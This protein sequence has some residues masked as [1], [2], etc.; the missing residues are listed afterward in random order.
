MSLLKTHPPM[1]VVL[2]YR[3]YSRITRVFKDRISSQNKGVALYANEKYL[4][5]EGKQ[6]WDVNV[7]IAW[8]R[9]PYVHSAMAYCSSSKSGGACSCRWNVLTGLIS[10]HSS[11]PQR[12]NK[13][14]LHSPIARKCWKHLYC[15]IGHG[16][17]EVWVV[18]R[19]DELIK[20][21]WAQ[22]IATFTHHWPR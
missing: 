2:N 14:Y 8:T 18:G 15:S 9:D 6:N 19:V 11:A 4:D 5:L 7:Y 17:I 13:Q 16:S 21:A 10:L 12:H 1:W 22:V 20:L 3:R